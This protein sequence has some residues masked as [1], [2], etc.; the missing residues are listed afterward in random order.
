[1]RSKT[2]AAGIA[3]VNH[4][5]GA[6]L[7]GAIVLWSIDAGLGYGTAV[8]FIAVALAFLGLFLLGWRVLVANARRIGSRFGAARG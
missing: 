5:I 7:A 8:A 1:M 6:E 4:P 2:A 3:A